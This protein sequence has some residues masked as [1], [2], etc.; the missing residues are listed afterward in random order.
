MFE[1]ATRQK[2]RFNT[3]RGELS[4]EQ[5]WD[6]PLQSASG[7][8]LDTLARGVNKELKDSNEESFVTA[9]T[10][11]SEKLFL[12]LA[13]I[14]HIIFVKLQEATVK[15]EEARRKSEIDKLT[16]ILERKKD[17]D[18]ENLSIEEL[19]TRLSKLGS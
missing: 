12:K 8:D 4:V 19:E 17:Q 18:L 2:L 3:Q 14:K 5:L 13:V 11:A 15:Q 7:V 6:L 16:Q 10:P 1:K 9:P